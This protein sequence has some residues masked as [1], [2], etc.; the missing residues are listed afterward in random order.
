[1]KC[2]E[3]SQN[4]LVGLSVLWSPRAELTVLFSPY[5]LISLYIYSER[6]LEIC[7]RSMKFI[8]EQQITF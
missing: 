5:A 8:N 4:T 7:I 2:M 6:A 3:L 1:M